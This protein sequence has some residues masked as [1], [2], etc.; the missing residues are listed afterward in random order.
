MPGLKEHEERSILMLGAP[1]TEVHVWLD[2]FYLRA[3]GV[4]HR[5][6][7]HHRLGIEL[8]VATLGEAARDA[9]EL[10]VEQ[11]FGRILPGPFELAVVLSGRGFDILPAQPILD[12]LWPGRFDLW[13]ID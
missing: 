11:D 12:E 7:L 8:G 13:D 4:A 1:W 2:R 5:I 3:P 10:H 9:L 6:A